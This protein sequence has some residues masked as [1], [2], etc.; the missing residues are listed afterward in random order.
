[1]GVKSISLIFQVNV[2]NKNAVSSI[3]EQLN[4]KMCLHEK[5]KVS[6]AKLHFSHAP[7]Q[8]DMPSVIS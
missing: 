3:H 2:F 5:P 8:H 4:A 1:M 7:F 6:Y